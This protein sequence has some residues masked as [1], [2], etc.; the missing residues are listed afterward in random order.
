MQPYYGKKI[1]TLIKL[2]G[3][4]DKQENGTEVDGSIVF[5]GSYFTKQKTCNAIANYYIQLLNLIE[6]IV[7]LLGID[8][9]G[10]TF[11]EARLKSLFVPGNDNRKKGYTRVCIKDQLQQ[12]NSLDTIPKM[13]I[14]KSFYNPEKALVINS[15]ENKSKLSKQ[16]NDFLSKMYKLFPRYL[17]SQSGGGSKRKIINRRKSKKIKQHKLY[18]LKNRNQQNNDSFRSTRENR[19]N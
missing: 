17:M 4:H 16:R 13:D 3:D 8:R 15:E 19:A 7:I 12:G 10:E 1:V 14:I 11:C 6:T 18:K 2:S 9:K 5:K